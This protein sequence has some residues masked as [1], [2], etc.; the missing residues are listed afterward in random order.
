MKA[1]K[2]RWNEVTWYSRLLA[3]VVFVAAPLWG[4]YLGYLY[5]KVSPVPPPVIVNARQPEQAAG[6]QISTSSWYTYQYGQYGFSFSYPKELE[7][8]NAPSSWRFLASSTSTGK[9]I[10]SLSVPPIFEMGTNFAGAAFSVGE[11][12]DGADIRNCFLPTDGETASSS[13]YLNGTMFY[14]FASSAAATGN[15]YR[16][17]SYR[18]MRNGAC[19]DIDLVVHST[20]IGN[21]PASF[22]V[23][24]FDKGKVDTLLSDVLR[25]FTFISS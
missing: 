11:S 9:G 10:I 15:Y 23:K 17:E 13:V 25:S 18:T 3:L 24:P 21:Y 6:Y 2:I 20:D 12:S 14:R 5:G 7:V 16:V 8:N 22:G 1:M 19:F 4:F